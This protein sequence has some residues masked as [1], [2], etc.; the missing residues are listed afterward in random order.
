[1]KTG[2][3]AIALL[4]L[5]LVAFHDGAPDHELEHQCIDEGYQNAVRGLYR[6]LFDRLTTN[7]PLDDEQAKASFKKGLERAR[8]SRVIALEALEE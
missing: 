1:M 2:F 3:I 5:G 8:R 7:P 6:N 4:V